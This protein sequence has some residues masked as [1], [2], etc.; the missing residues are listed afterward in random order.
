MGSS[1][2]FIVNTSVFDFLKSK[3]EWSD[4]LKKPEDT[5]KIKTSLLT[6]YSTLNLLSLQKQNFN[7]ENFQIPLKMACQIIMEYDSLKKF[8][9]ILSLNVQAVSL[10]SRFLIN[11]PQNTSK[12]ISTNVN[13]AQ[14]LASWI[15]VINDIHAKNAL[16]ICCVAILV[17]LEVFPTEN[18]LPSIEGLLTISSR[19][20][21]LSV[22][23]QGK[24]QKERHRNR[25][26][27]YSARKEEIRKL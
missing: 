6:V 24:P 1:K 20:V 11:D 16:K 5:L 9:E 13:A 4:N 25:E 27:G 3:A 17:S 10:F 21:Y 14:F 7:I 22:E 19:Q 15:N 26:Q 12:F 18:T 23:L 8:A 2:I